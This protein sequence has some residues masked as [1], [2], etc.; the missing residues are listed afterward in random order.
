MCLKWINATAAVYKEVNFDADLNPYS[1]SKALT[2]I[3]LTKS[4]TSTLDGVIPECYIVTQWNFIGTNGK[5]SEYEANPLYDGKPKVYDV[6]IRLTKCD[7]DP[8]NQ[9][10]IDLDQFEIDLKKVYLHKACFPYAVLT[11]VTPVIGLNRFPGAGHYVIKV[12]IRNKS[13]GEDEKYT[14]QAMYPLNIN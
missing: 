9:Q 10:K 5:G 11:Y 13:K 7:T 3:T 12:L 2:S 1:F 6:I 4:G 14:I 8:N